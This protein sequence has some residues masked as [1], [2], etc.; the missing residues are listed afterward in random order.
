M[1][2][3]FLLLFASVTTLTYGQSLT[4]VEQDTVVEINSTAVADYGF[5][6]KIKNT[7][8]EDLEIMVRRAY[9]NPTC[10]YDSGYFCWDYCYGADIDNSIGHVAI[11]AGME[12]NDFSGHV[13]SPSTS[14]SCSD[15]TRY[16]FYSGKNPNDSLSVWVTISA[17]PT[18]GTLSLEVSESRLYPN[19]AK[20]ST[21]IEVQRSSELAI[22]NALG[23]LVKRESLLPGTNTVA[24]HDLS[25]GVYLYSLDGGT[26]KKLIVSH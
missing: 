26:Y 5:H 1:K 15:S 2:R 25:N 17:G 8:T 10:A 6:I 16:V 22:Y 21:T 23:A 14:A 24:L 20:N 13:Y 11:D 19:P 12:K 18:M 4:V 7:S 3:L 9:A